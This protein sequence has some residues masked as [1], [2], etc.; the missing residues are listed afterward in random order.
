[1][2]L[3]ID[4]KQMKTMS[5]AMRVRFELDSMAMLR[6]TYPEFTARHVDE[7]LHRFVR[8]GIERAKLSNMTTVAEIERWLRLMMQLGPYFDTAGDD[9]LD[10][11][12]TV[13][14]KVDI[15]GPIRLDEAEAMALRIA[16]AP[17]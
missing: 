12:R 4:A 7:T 13:I 11:I 16:P 8:H 14:H 2:A 9:G 3:H 1:M 10:H 17:K 5:D 6:Q 15:Y